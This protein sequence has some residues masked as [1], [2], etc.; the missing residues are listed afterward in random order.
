MHDVAVTSAD[1]VLGGTLAIPHGAHGLI[2]FAHGSGSSR[3]SPRNRAVAGL[4]NK[5]GFAT[6]LMDLLTDAEEELDTRTAAL[7]FDIALLARR[8]SEASDWCRAD[9]RLVHLPLG[10]FGASTGAAAALLSAADRDDVRAIVSRGG[11]PDLAGNALARVAAPTLLVVGER[12]SVVVDLNRRA[13]S[14]MPAHCEIAIVP[15]AGHLFE[16]AGALE[17][18]AAL[19]TDWFVRYLAALARNGS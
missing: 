9:Q 6:L 3:Y 10:Y 19:A 15:A 5:R 4:L 12:D 17:R 14:E 7:R 8:V 16:E 2:L 13:A 11:R 1:G 18:V